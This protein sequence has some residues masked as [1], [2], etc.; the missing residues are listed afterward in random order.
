MFKLWRGPETLK[1]KDPIALSWPGN[2][3]GL[4]M[5]LGNG[6]RISLAM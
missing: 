3:R 2:S 6:I 5:N 4:S 1:L